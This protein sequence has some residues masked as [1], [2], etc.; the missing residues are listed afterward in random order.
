MTV[1]D[2]AFDDVPKD[3]LENVFVDLLSALSSIKELSVLGC[4]HDD[5]ESLIKHAL[6]ALVHNQDMER[7]SF[8]KLVDDDRLVNVTGLSYLETIDDEEYE[9][10]TQ[11][12]EFKV[13]EGLIGV[14]AKTR[15]LQHCHNSATDERFSREGNGK[16]ARLPGSIISVPVFTAN[17]ELAG[18]LNVSHPEPYFF[19]EWHVRLLEVYK[20]IFGQLITNY[21]LIR[22]MESE[23][24]ARTAKLQS[25]YE[26]IK[27][28]KDYYQNISVLDSLTGLYN[29]RYFYD[30]MKVVLANYRRYHQPLCV[31]LLDLD[32]FKAINDSHGHDMGDK[33]LV[34]ISDILRREVRA[35]DILVRFGGEEFVIVFTNTSCKNGLRFAERIRRKISEALVTIEGETV[36]VTASIGL[37]CLDKDC[38]FDCCDEKLGD[39][40]AEVV[41]KIIK[42][43]DA[44]L[45]HAKAKGRDQVVRYCKDFPG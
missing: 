22:S 42:F 2:N 39:D 3:G 32:H 25:A 27:S 21:R 1:Q 12:Q 19:T 11:P 4:Q 17:L 8:F 6:A 43:A 7:C 44:A 45:Y 24:A 20:N 30:Q 18:V 9:A 34:V 33:V 16:N 10:S 29:R 15:T 26:E 13:G 28:L 35:N 38:Q 36:Q 40:H 14:A 31:L 23:I 41:S 5:E 37:F